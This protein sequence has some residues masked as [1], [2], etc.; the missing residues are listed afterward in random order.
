[1][2]I[3]LYQPDIAQNT[4]TILRLAACLSTPVDI[5]GPTGFDMSD[6]A[7]R[8]AGLDY[9]DHV[10]IARHVSFEAFV[11]S[12]SRSD[13]RL[14]AMT[15][16]ANYSVYDFQFRDSDTLLFG[17]ESAGLPERVHATAD[18]RLRIPLK[19]GLRSLNLAVAT[20]IVLAEALRQTGG[21]PQV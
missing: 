1:M 9:L 15:T 10:E 20:G 2:R 3:A 4:G 11:A 17:R 18:A 14:L 7:L 5:I 6:R 19:A 8:R 13:S 21:L 16:H 12:R